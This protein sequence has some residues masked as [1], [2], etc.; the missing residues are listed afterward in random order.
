MAKKN[1]AIVG[2]SNSMT[3]VF[4]EFYKSLE[5]HDGVV[6][7]LDGM[8]GINFP[9]SRGHI[10]PAQIKHPMTAFHLDVGK[11]TS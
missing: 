6:R 3:G 1:N 4:Q 5:N 9:P 11:V 2:R 10:V 8:K 7:V